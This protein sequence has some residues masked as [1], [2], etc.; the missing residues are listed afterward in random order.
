MEM[1]DHLEDLR[2]TLIKCLITVAVAFLACF[3]FYE[4]LLRWIELP[5]IDT[6]PVEN[7]KIVHQTATEISIERIGPPLMILGPLEGISIAIKVCLWGALALAAPF[8]GY[9]LLQF[10]TPGMHSHER[11]M[12]IPFA[13]LSLLAMGLGAIFAQHFTL[14]LSNTFLM[15]FN[16]SIGLNFWTL[17]QTL[18][19][20]IV[21][22]L[23][24]MIAF[25]L[26]AILLL[27]THY[28]WIGPDQLKSHRKGAILSSLILGALLT[29]PDV[30]TQILLAAPLIA[31]YELA[32]WYAGYRNRE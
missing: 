32:I 23:A 31:S 2:S 26:I 10:A 21:L 22:L 5:F 7:F 16:Q 9:F 3:V 28:R 24:H 4:P 18:D 25:E 30:L 15:N 1:G 11:N 14:P 27:L 13:L 12:V 8:W 29:P 19:Y 6:R 20:T 17:E